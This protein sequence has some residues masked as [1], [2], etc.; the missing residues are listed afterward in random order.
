MVHNRL[1]TQPILSSLDQFQIVY[2]AQT[3]LIGMK[4]HQQAPRA[5][6]LVIL[7]QNYAI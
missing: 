3:F 7:E 5:S 6:D 1:L 4:N 2:G